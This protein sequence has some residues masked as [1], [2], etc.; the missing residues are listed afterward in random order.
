[1]RVGTSG[2]PADG[3]DQRADDEE[4]DKDRPADDAQDAPRALVRER[5]RVRQ[6]RQHHEQD[7]D[8]GECRVVARPLVL[9]L[10]CATGSVRSLAA[11]TAPLLL[12]LLLLR[13]FVV[14]CCA[15]AV[16]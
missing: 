6:R 2:I 11:T 5:H 14:F 10:C 16:G 13:T 3:G 8:H 12:L 4:V 1:M 15:V 7:Q 9:G